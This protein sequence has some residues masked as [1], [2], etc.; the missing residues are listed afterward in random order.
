[1][2]FTLRR[3]DEQAG[4]DPDVRDKS[5]FEGPYDVAK[6]DEIRAMIQVSR[7]HIAERNVTVMPGDVSGND[8]VCRAGIE[9]LPS[10]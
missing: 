3:G 9:P 5:S 10:D 1:M 8:M 2:I 6:T 7:Y 4:G